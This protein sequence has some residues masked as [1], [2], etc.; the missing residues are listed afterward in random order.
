MSRCKTVVIAVDSSKES[1]FALN[2]A[3]NNVIQ[4]SDT[5]FLLNVQSI[6]QSV[7]FVDLF[8]EDS[9]NAQK[10][11]SVRSSHSLLDK[12]GDL[13]SNEKMVKV[14]L[15]GSDVGEEIV[16]KSGEVGADLLVVGASQDMNFLKR[17]ISGSV[18]DYCL[19]H[20]KFSVVV[21]RPKV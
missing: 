9:Y 5:I 15:C 21:P 16:Q 19:H 11:L 12:L 10:E 8:D 7:S 2:W 14:S 3:I 1:L 13:I 6:D 18:G 4:Q 20:S 17:A